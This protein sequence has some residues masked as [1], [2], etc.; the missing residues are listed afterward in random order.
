MKKITIALLL[1]SITLIGCE[2]YYESP[3]YVLTGSSCALEEGQYTEEIISDLW[4][5]KITGGRV[6]GGT[7]YSITITEYLM[8]VD[9]LEAVFLLSA[10]QWETL[11]IGGTVKVPLD[12]KD[13]KSHL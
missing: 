10:E 6:I 9:G 11:E 13:R 2:V 7:M 1:M 5:D 8:M 12:Y 4:I 3:K